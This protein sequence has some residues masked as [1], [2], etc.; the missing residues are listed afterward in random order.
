M[1]HGCYSPLD[2]IAPPSN[3]ELAPKPLIRSKLREVT[4]CTVLRAYATVS[5]SE[6]EASTASGWY[7]QFY[8]GRRP[9]SSLE[10]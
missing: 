6:A 10:E 8:N 4:S 5:E 2:E 1:L 7:L 9:H 3:F